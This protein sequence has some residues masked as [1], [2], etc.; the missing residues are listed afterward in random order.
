MQY[1][2]TRDAQQQ[3]IT[4][5][6]AIR[7]GIAADGGLYVPQSFP[8]YMPP[9]WHNLDYRQLARD[10]FSLYLTDFTPTE[11]TEIVESAYSA[12]AFPQCVAPCVTVGG[13]QIL[14]LFHGPTLAFKDMALQALPRLLTHAVAKCG[15]GKEV[16]ILVATS[17]DTG[18]AALEGFKDIP[19]CRII[20]FYPAGGVSPIQEKQMLT[21]GGHNTAVVAVAGNFDD[22]QTGVKRLFADT[23]LQQRMSAAG[24]E[25][26]SANSINFGRLLPQIV[27]YYYG[28][29]QMVS[30]GRIQPGQQIQ[31]VVPTGNFGN[32]LAAYYAREMGLPINRLVCASNENDVLTEVIQNGYYNRRRPF[33]KTTSP[34]MD[35]LVSSNFERFLFEMYGRDAQACAAALQTLN[36]TGAVQI[37]AQAREHWQGFLLAGSAGQADAAAAIGSVFKQ[38][39]YVLDPHTAVGWQVWQQLPSTLPTLLAATASPY[40]FPAAVLAALGHNMPAG[41]AE[42]QLQLLSRLSGTPLPPALTELQQLPLRHSR[43]CAIA[44]MGQTVTEI[45][46]L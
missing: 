3:P 29:G 20:V 13:A 42:E 39:G 4:A 33:Y 15:G 21:T 27:Y 8:A 7:R 45:L 31:V 11:I 36:E 44:D 38:H 24:K 34:S 43:Q 1:V 30:S 41:S 16:V 6:E 18:K 25:F 23:A 2:S 5:A 35:I 10:I 14:E 28:Y 32:I 37:S 19:G 46:S 26:S 12:T 40:K 22:C 9:S 17:G